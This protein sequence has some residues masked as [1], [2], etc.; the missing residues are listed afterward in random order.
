MGGDRTLC[1][2]EGIL[3]QLLQSGKRGVDSD[4]SFKEPV[5]RAIQLSIS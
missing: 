4:T 1:Q 5:I 2:G 3:L